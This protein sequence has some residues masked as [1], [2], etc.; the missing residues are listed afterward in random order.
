MRNTCKTIAGTERMAPYRGIRRSGSGI[1]EGETIATRT[2]KM[3]RSPCKLP[4]KDV[5]L[6]T[7]THLTG[8]QK[9][10]R[11]NQSDARPVS[12]AAEALRPA[13]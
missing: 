2:W 1:Y 4:S 8:C 3:K 12:R 13:G 5:N 7:S 10:N 6:S 9:N 11:L